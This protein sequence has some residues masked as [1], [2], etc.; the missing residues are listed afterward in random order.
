[1]IGNQQM[2]DDEH[3]F[4]ANLIEKIEVVEKRTIP[5][6][7]THRLKIGSSFV[8]SDHFH[9]LHAFPSFFLHSD[10]AQY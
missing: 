5:R 2:I 7:R 1:M 6:D 8:L 3:F 4:V 10:D 9:P